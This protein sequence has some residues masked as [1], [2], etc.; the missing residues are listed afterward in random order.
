MTGQ[1]EAE[2]IYNQAVEF[3]VPVGADGKTQFHW[4]NKSRK[5]LICF[6]R[7]LISGT[8]RPMW[9]FI[10]AMLREVGRWTMRTLEF[11]GSVRPLRPD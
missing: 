7:L 4:K 5:R 3:L 1:E 8:W 6:S 11:D 10:T 2:S 9:I